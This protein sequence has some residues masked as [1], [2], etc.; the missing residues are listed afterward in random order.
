M[1]VQQD[2]TSA[3][4]AVRDLQRT[5]EELRRRYP[6]SLDVRRFAVD[7][8]RVGEDLDMLSPP[9]AAT[10]AQQR[11]LEII[12]DRDYPADFWADA[13]DEGVGRH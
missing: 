1:T 4:T 8:A 7:A 5:A 10:A 13:E 6:D 2:L 12:E 9:P 3:R 11:P